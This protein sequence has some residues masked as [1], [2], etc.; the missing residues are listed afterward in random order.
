MSRRTDKEWQLYPEGSGYDATLRC[1]FTGVH[2]ATQRS[3]TELTPAMLL[4]RNRSGKDQL[5]QV[6]LTEKRDTAIVPKIKTKR[7]LVSLE[8][9]TPVC[10][11]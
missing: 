3:L 5:V 9:D 4:G 10:R 6:G 2:R 7:R 11:A 1:T 8:G